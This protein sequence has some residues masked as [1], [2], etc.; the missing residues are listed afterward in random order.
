MRSPEE[1]SEGP[2][3]DLGADL[4]AAATGA[5]NVL[6]EANQGASLGLSPRL[7]AGFS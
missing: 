4:S 3:R 1:A 5:A 7:A 2:V 6:R